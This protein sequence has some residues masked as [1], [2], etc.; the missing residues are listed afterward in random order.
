MLSIDELASEIKDNLK[1][2]ERRDAEGLPALETPSGIRATG[3]TQLING[4]EITVGTIR[5]ADES[6]TVLVRLDKPQGVKDHMAL[7]EAMIVIHRDLVESSTEVIGQCLDI[8]RA[9]EGSGSN[10]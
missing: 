8:P 10:A 1:M 2:L 4:T 3:Q 5:E 9:V 7:I 6:F